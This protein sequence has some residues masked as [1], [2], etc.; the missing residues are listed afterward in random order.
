MYL[1]ILL[2]FLFTSIFKKI[3]FNSRVKKF[4]FFLEKFYFLNHCFYI[5][6]GNIL[7]A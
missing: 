7:L 6:K 3:L 2:F 5:I 1:K 4:N